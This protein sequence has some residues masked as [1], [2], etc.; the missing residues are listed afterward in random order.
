MSDYFTRFR[1]IAFRKEGAVLEMR[2]HTDD[3]PLKFSGALHEDLGRA[4]HC[5]GEDRS[6]KVL[7]LTGSGD[8]FCTEAEAEGAD[9]DFSFGTWLKWTRE[10]RT[11]FLNLLEVDVPV[12]SAINGPVTMHSEL[13]ILADIVIASDSTYF[14]DSHMITGVVPGDGCHAIWNLMLG[15]SRGH[16]Y[17]LTSETMTAQTAHHFGVVHEIHPAGQ[18]LG[19]AWE[20]A[21]QL[22]RQTMDTLR[23]TR[24]LFSQ[25]LKESLIRELGPGMAFE[26]LSAI[27]MA[28]S[29]AKG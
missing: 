7:I 14:R 17:L 23:Y 16:Y 13:P 4:F 29:A 26:G 6:I 25:P 15:R 8:R 11:M 10:A 2:L 19:R 22:E 3:G 12:I 18:V 24:M 27:S 21:R 1:N 9:I 20:L 5:I 28:Q